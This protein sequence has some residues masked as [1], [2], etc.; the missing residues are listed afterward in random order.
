MCPDLPLSTCD[1]G[2]PG[3]KW[4]RRGDGAARPT[5]QGGKA[6]LPKTNATSFG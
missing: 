4:F 5:V 3:S 1:Q 6:G 2:V